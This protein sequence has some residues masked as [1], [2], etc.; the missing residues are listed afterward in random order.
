MQNIEEIKSDSRIEWIDIAKGIGIICVVIGHII[1]I[2]PR[3]TTLCEMIYLFHVPLFFFISG[4]LYKENPKQI[5]YISKK[6]KQLVVPYF[7]VFLFIAPIAIYI[8]H[9]SLNLSDLLFYLRKY[10]WGGEQLNIILYAVF[11]PMWFLPSLFLTQVIYNYIKNLFKDIMIHIIVLILYIINIFQTLYWNDISL[12]FFL[13]TVT[14]SIP[15]YHLGYLFHKIKKINII[16]LILGC[17]AL[18]SPVFIPD[19]YI[20]LFRSNSG[21]PVLT[22]ISSILVV[23]GIISFSKKISG[24]FIAN[25]L[26]K[27][28]QASLVIMSFHFPVYLCFFYLKCVDLDSPYI[29]LIVLLWGVVVLLICYIFYIVFEKFKI[30]RILFLGNK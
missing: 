28:G 23:V 11:I 10:I 17:I 19:N 20:A 29:Y 22:F 8:E 30:T 15:I 21:I 25:I 24:T 2:I 3:L 9:G 1:V 5:S 13:H 16:V 27:L 6:I 7:S 26:R 12:P 4:F 18:L 14:L